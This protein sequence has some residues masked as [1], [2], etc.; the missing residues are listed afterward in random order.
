MATTDH[1]IIDTDN[2]MQINGL[3]RID[4]TFVNAGTVTG[5]LKDTAGATITGASSI[6][7][8]YVA[9]SNGNWTGSFPSTVTLTEDKEYH[10]F[11]TVVDGSNDV[12]FRI[13]RPA[14]F[15]DL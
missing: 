15:L 2:S 6:T 13:R 11:L 14:R 1:W 4:G 10:L 9:A 3:K 8:S 12:T 7:F 5:V